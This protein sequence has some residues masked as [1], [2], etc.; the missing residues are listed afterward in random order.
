MQL[1]LNCGSPT[2]VRARSTRITS[3]FTNNFGQPGPPVPSDS[4]HPSTTP[5]NQPSP[6][7]LN[8]PASVSRA[9]F[10]SP[11]AQPARSPSRFPSIM[12]NIAP[13]LH[14]PIASSPSILL[15]N[16]PS[17]PPRLTR[18]E[19]STTNTTQLDKI[20]GLAMLVAATV[21]FLYYT[22]WTLLMV[23]F[24]N[25]SPKCARSPGSLFARARLPTNSRPTH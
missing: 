4:H 1:W 11:I 14:D 25:P 23:R 2:P 24:R 21:V 8:Q 15:M 20:V 13:L 3:L 12:V 9:F 17:P 19:T 18:S 22:I 10:P 16:S 5:Y 7:S 6:R